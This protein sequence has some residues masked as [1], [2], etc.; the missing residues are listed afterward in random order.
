MSSP[1]HSRMDSVRICSSS[2]L[3]FRTSWHWACHKG[4]KHAHQDLTRVHSTSD[5]GQGTRRAQLT[6]RFLKDAMHFWMSGRSGWLSWTETEGDVLV[7]KSCHHRV[8]T[9]LLS[10]DVWIHTSMCLSS[11]LSKVGYLSSLMKGLLRPVVRVRI[12]GLTAPLP[13]INSP[14]TSLQEEGKTDKV[15][16]CD[17]IGAD[18]SMNHT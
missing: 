2:S 11:S 16:Y 7:I 8:T 6:D 4:D 1:S 9:G 3:R 15:E 18:L 17:S 10:T 5:Q 14:S 12:P 13:S